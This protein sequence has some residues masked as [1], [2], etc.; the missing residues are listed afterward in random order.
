MTVWAYLVGLSG[1]VGAVIAAVFAARASTRA[2]AATAEAQRA[3]A[4]ISSEPGQREQDRAAFAAITDRLEKEVV[5]E[6]RQR[7]LLT[8]YVL[9][10]LRWARLVGPDTVAGPP[11]NPPQDLDLTPWHVQ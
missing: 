5:E 3:T 6:R 1:A 2:A 10:M 7:R 9:D 8:S 11:P 4:R